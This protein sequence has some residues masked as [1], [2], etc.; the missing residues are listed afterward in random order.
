MANGPISAVV[1]TCVP[2]Q[3]SREKPSTSID[4][5]DVAVL[6]AE[7]H[8]RAEL[9]RLVDRRQER[10]HRPVLEDRFV[11]DLLDAAALLRASAPA[12]A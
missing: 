5:H 12:G 9:P 6:L 1:R 7:E 2:P 11:D 4:A 8:H 3:S 10:A